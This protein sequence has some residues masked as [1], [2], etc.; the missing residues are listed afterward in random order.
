MSNKTILP[1][2]TDADYSEVFILT[3]SGSNINI[4]CVGLAA[5]ETAVLRSYDKTS[6]TWNDLQRN[7]EPYFLMSSGNNNIN[8]ILENGK[9]CLYKTATE[10]EVGIEIDYQ[11]FSVI[12][13]GETGA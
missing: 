7:G 13:T 2:T 9:F 1:P 5:D 10:A 4:S 12:F 11:P 3:G 8:A 6:D